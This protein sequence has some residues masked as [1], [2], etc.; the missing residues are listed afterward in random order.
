VKM[1]MNTVAKRSRQL[2]RSVVLPTRT[3]IVEHLTSGGQLRHTGARFTVAPPRNADLGTFPVQ[4]YA[5]LSAGGKASG[6]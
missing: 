6:R 4:A 1:V 5:S 3:P 2:V